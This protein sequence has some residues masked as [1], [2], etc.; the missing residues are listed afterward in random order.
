MCQN[1]DFQKE[2]EALQY[3]TV[4]AEETALEASQQFI[5]DKR[6]LSKALVEA[7]PSLDSLT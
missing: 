1:P 6:E 2:M 7:A 3:T 4:S 5:M